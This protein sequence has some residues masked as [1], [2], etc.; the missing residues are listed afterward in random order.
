MTQKHLAYE[1][2]YYRWISSPHPHH[3]F[4]LA[5]PYCSLELAESLESE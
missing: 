5:L 4:V 3:V 2:Y 1:S